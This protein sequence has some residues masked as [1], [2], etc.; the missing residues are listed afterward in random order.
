MNNPEIEINAAHDGYAALRARR[1]I[2]MFEAAAVKTFVQTFAEWDR[3][4][5]G[6]QSGALPGE[7]ECFARSV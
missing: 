5:A 1:F 7:A 6:L 3:R 4:E 2:Q